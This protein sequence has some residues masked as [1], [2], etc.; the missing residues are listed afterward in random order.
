M[1]I[2]DY[3]VFFIYIA[4]TLVLGFTAGRLARLRPSDYFLGEKKLLR[5]RRADGRLQPL[6][7]WR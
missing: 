2:I 7:Y 1:S 6:R 5:P 3:A 4:A